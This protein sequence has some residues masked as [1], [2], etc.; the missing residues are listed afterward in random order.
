MVLEIRLSNFYSIKDEITLDLR[1]GNIQTKQAKE[2][3]ANVFNFKNTKV[4][5][6]VA[7]YGANASGKT[8]IVKAIR[9]CNMMVLQSHNHNEDAVFNFVPFKF[10]GYPEKPSSYFIRFV[11]KGIEYE[12]SFSLTRTEIITESL[13]FYPKGRI[14]KIFVRDETAGKTK[15]EKYNFGSFIK[16]PFD[17]AENTSNKTLYISRASQMDREIPKMIFNFFNSKFLNNIILFD[18]TKL[19]VLFNEYKN[20][21]IRGLQIADS[22]IVD[23]QI[24]KEVGNELKVDFK[25]EDDKL[26]FTN[27][28]DTRKEI[29]RFISY[30]KRDKNIAFDFRSEESDGTK[31]MF[32]MLLTILSVVK[33]N[34][35]LLIDEFEEKLHSHIAEF[36]LKL[37][38]LSDN[39]QLI[40]TTHNTNLL[41]LKKL[42]KDQIYFCNKKE[43]ASTELYSLYDFKD[44]RDT[45]DVEKAYLQGRF[46]AIPFINDSEE[47]IS[48]LIYE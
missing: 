48:Q 30:H 42:R 43:D 45:M 27:I 8:N 33:N 20:D 5:K 18:D 44:F 12:Y 36:I 19:E 1:A 4:V 39:A 15:K 26:S 17:V 10:E 41:D 47:N 14:A 21:L 29:I 25:T 11:S 37:F 13:Y 35:V 28:S 6:T 9:F 31:K 24:K 38:N 3:S 16:R 23:L 7:M 40:F 22:D 2:L 46:D 34:G 32:V